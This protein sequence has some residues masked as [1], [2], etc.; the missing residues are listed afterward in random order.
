MSDHPTHSA[1]YEA[2]TEADND[3]EEALAAIRA[4]QDAGRITTLAAA[5]ERITVLENHL[6]LCRRLRIE[7]LAGE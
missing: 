5:N 2:V 3:L 7:H 4:E 6:A 1:F